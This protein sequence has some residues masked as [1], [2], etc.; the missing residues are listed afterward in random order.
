MK[1]REHNCKSVAYP[2]PY[3]TDHGVSLYKAIE[4]YIESIYRHSRE[5]YIG[6]TSHPE[7]RLFEHYIDS[8]RE[9]LTILHWSNDWHAIDNIEHRFIVHFKDRIKRKNKSHK[10]D[11]AL[12]GPWNS[13][14]VSWGKKSG[15]PGPD[16]QLQ[17]TVTELSYS[18]RILWPVKN[19]HLQPIT[20]RVGM[21]AMQAER[22]MENINME[23]KDFSLL[24][25][26]RTQLD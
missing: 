14:Y 4:Q 22:Q 1:C 17:I 25:R 9:Y 21:S 24:K 12:S 7:A 19:Q 23:A 18:S 6:R 20:L 16:V 13:L 15:S 3:C 26:S 10:S 11:G 2:D 5:I 8:G